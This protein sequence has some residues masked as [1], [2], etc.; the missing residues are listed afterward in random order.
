MWDSS[1]IRSDDGGASWTSVPALG[2]AMFPGPNFATPAFIDYGQHPATGPHQAA[3]YVYALSTTGHWNNG[4]AMTLGR[5]P[6]DRIGRL[7]PADWEFAQGFDP[8]PAPD[9][10]DPVA[11]DAARE[12]VWDRRHDC[13]LPVFQSPGRTSMAGATWVAPLGRYLLPQ[14]HFP[15]LERPNP[16]RWQHSRWQVYSAPAP[17]GPWSLFLEHDFAPEGFYN[18]SMPSRFISADGTRMWLLTCGDFST[19]AYYAMHAV[20]VTLTAGESQAG[21]DD[22]P[23]S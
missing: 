13:A 15:A 16:R 5:V 21:S 11:G 14:W 7:D 12:P 19:H 3:E 22:E 17:W 8:N 10:A 20:E 1:L 9:L 18:P 23:A 4:H 6:R 2:A